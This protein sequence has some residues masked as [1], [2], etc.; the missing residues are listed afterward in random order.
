MGNTSSTGGYLS[1]AASPAPLEGQALNIFL[2]N[3]IVGIT[4]LPG[5]YV[6]PR[7]QPEPPNI[8]DPTVDWIAFGITSREADTFAAEV[9]QAGSPGNNQMRR[10]EIVHILVTV[11]GPNA[12]RTA[13]ILREGMQVPQNHEVLSSNNMG[14][15]SSG[16]IIQTSEI[17]KQQWVYRLDFEFAIK[18]QIVYEYPVEEIL[19]VSGTLN[20]EIYTTPIA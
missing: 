12:D 15:A 16:D 19:T 8:P 9:H 6:R 18:R 2:Q 1:P 20:N 5:Q 11:Y 10:H 17:L 7:W 3:W 13:S 4:G 14:F